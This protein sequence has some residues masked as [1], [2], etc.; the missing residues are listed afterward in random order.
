MARRGFAVMT[1]ERRREIAAMGGRAAHEKGTAHCFTTET[2]KVAGSK[3]GKAPH[4]VR[5]RT[6][7]DRKDVELPEESA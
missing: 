6:V 1:P 4:R 2:A 7:P 5:G 3:G